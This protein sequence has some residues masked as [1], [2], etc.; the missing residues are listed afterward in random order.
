MKMKLKG[1]SEEETRAILSDGNG[2]QRNFILLGYRGSIAH[3]T[4]VKNTEPNSVD[5]KDV[6][7]IFIG[8]EKHYIGFEKKE[9]GEKIFKEWDIVQ[10]ELR[11][12]V[13]LLLKSNPNVLMML[14]LPEKYYLHKDKYG[15]ML[16]QN[17][18]IFV[19]RHA[20]HSFSGYAYGQFKRMTNFRFDGYMGAKRK[21]LVEKYGY[22]TK[23]AAHLIRLL[24][25]GIE[26]LTEGNLFVEREDAPQLISIKNG[27]WT[28]EQ[29]KRESDKLFG[30]AQQAYINSKLKDKPD[31]ERA[32]R[33]LMD[34]IREYLLSKWT[35]V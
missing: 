13:S 21:A 32:E 28:L 17:R 34:I 8:T 18:D 19:S 24:K 4:Y 20:Y 29:V 9:V 25:M 31:Y 2:N 10:Y 12:F 5:D 14:W 26:F 16:I 30:L 1:L 15:E 6:M 33:L 7:G 23:N 11:K 22:D 35:M 27:E 3:G